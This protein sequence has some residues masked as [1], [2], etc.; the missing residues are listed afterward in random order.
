MPAIDFPSS[1]TNGQEFTS[2]NRTWIWDGSVWNSKETSAIEV[3]D[4][5]ANYILTLMSAI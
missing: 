5:Q 2:G 3:P 1:P 4:I